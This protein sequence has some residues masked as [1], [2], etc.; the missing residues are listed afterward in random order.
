M[1][2]TDGKPSDFERRA[3]TRISRTLSIHADGN[4][5]GTVDGDDDDFNIMALTV[6]DGFRPSEHSHGISSFSPGSTYSNPTSGSDSRLSFSSIES[7][8]S[9]HRSSI[10]AETASISDADS[11]S[12]PASAPTPNASD[13][14]DSSDSSG[15]SDSSDSSDPSTASPSVAYSPQPTAPSKVELHE[16]AA[17]AAAAAAQPTP[18]T[19]PGGISNRP[20]S[21]TK[22]PIGSSSLGSSSGAG[23][24]S[25]A[26]ASEHASSSMPVVQGEEPYQGPSGPSFPYQLYPQN[27]RIARTLSGITTATAAPSESSYNGP[28]GPTFPYSLYPQSTMAGSGAVPTSAIPVGFPGMADGYQRR[29]GPDGEDIA[30]MIGPDG[31]TEQL[32]PYSRYPDNYS[33]KMAA[34]MA[35]VPPA[36]VNAAGVVGVVDV[37]GVAGVADVAGVAGVAGASGTVSALSAV[38]TVGAATTAADAA[39]AA[40]SAAETSAAADAASEPNIAP[41]AVP[42]AVPDLAPAA[43]SDQAATTATAAATTTETTTATATAAAATTA[44]AAAPN[45]R[46]IPGAGGIGLAPR[47]PEF[48]SAEDLD[49]PQSRHSS[50]SFTS[51]ASQNEINAAGTVY[52]EKRLSPRLRQLARRRLFGVIPYWAICLAIIALVI[53]CIVLGSV[54]GVLLTRHHKPPPHT[55]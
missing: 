7:P 37:A 24:S 5:A 28:R 1:A 20:S 10:A 13:L 21:I 3:S 16:A 36:P 25:A 38:G 6:A 41:G 46:P 8:T 30:D 39:A 32:P 2:P 50:R 14:A 49:S 12:A 33:G 42:V 4:G 54:I 17:A 29:L 43:G 52:N 51:D 55:R 31:H 45:I 44:V 27:V 47:N 53:M 34:V 26:H 19:A 11:A 35:A 9:Q 22:L 15:S 40:G 48:D 23:S 18:P